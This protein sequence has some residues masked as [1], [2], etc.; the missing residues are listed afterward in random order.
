[1]CGLLT[2]T[3]AFPIDNSVVT[4]LQSALRKELEIDDSASECESESGM[5]GGNYFSNLKKFTHFFIFYLSFTL[6]KL[7]I[8]FIFEAY[9]SLGSFNLLGNLYHLIGN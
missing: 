9:S 8:L 1:M 2:G 3:S 7:N 5:S 4:E 6:F